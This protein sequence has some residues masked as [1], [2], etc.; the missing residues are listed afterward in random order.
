MVIGWHHGMVVGRVTRMAARVSPR[1][2][3]AYRTTISGI[4]L[5]L[6]M[7]SRPYEGFT[8]HL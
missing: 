4:Q 3:W 1:L 2:A 8:G 6:G 7:L 5:Y